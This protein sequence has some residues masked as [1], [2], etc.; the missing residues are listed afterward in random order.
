MPGTG[1]GGRCAYQGPCSSRVFGGPARAT[2][3]TIRRNLINIPARIAASAR[4]IPPGFRWCCSWLSSGEAVELRA[5]PA[6]G[7]LLLNGK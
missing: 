6:V 4:R 5:R 3:A 1:S 2:G 7:R